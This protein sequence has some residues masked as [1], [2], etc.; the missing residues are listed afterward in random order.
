MNEELSPKKRRAIV[1]YMAWMFA[2]AFLLV[3]LSLLLK[4]HIGNVEEIEDASESISVLQEEL[5]VLRAENAVLQEQL[6]T[7]NLS[8]MERTAKASELLALAQNALY[9]GDTV[10]F[11][12]YMAMLEGNANALPADAAEIYNELLDALS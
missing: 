12:A 10:K 9:K 1:K 11:H 3:A 4:M 2:G 6:A 7:E 8:D 5:D